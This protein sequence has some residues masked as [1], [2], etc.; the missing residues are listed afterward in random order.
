MTVKSPLRG[1]LPT[2]HTRGAYG[3]WL[4]PLIQGAA[5]VAGAGSNLRVQTCSSVLGFSY[6][7][8]PG[9]N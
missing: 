8:P 5:I 1:A 9:G 6:L 4:I 2:S 3:P 7:L